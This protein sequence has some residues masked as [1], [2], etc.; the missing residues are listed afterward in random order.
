MESLALRSVKVSDN[1]ALKYVL[2]LYKEI[3]QE[4]ALLCALSET[5]GILQSVSF[6]SLSEV[7]LCRVMPLLMSRLIFSG[8]D[9]AV[10]SDT[11]HRSLLNKIY[12]D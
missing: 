3:L 5:I 4:K 2:S 12:I 6:Q 7:L 11:H 9:W 8:L 1:Y 10:Q